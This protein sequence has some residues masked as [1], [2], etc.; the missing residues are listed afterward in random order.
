MSLLPMDGVDL[1]ADD[2]PIWRYL[3][4][5][6]FIRLLECSA[7]WLTRIDLLDDPR[8]GCLTDKEL[9]VLGEDRDANIRF[10]NGHRKHGYVNCWFAHEHE[11]MA[12]WRLYGTGP[13]GVA[14][15]S[16]IRAM[17]DAM[18]TVPHTVI[19]GSVRYLRWRREAP[20]DNNIILMCLRKE[21][22]FSHER[23]VRLVVWPMLFNDIPI[24]NVETGE[25]MRIVNVSGIA[26][27][28]AAC[29]VKLPTPLEYDE[30]TLKRTCLEAVMR[31]MQEDTDSQLKPGIEI[32]VQLEQLISEVRVGPSEPQWVFDLVQS[33][34][35]RFGFSGPINYSDLRYDM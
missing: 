34:A 29:L 33:V 3:D 15:K 22:S 32:P 35:R 30:S 26:N 27:D 20:W 10:M 16:T 19:M 28:M 11:S 4:L 9:Y 12:M 6:R 25:G 24:V 7:L 8:E 2:K 23:E 5:V 17:K 1:P 31:Q 14:V 13:G 21:E 18:A